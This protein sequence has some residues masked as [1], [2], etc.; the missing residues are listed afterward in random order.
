MIVLL[1]FAALAA[2]PTDWEKAETPYLKNIRQVTRDYVRAGEGYF[3]PDGKTI[4]FQAEEKDTGNPFYQIFLQ[5]LAT[6]QVRRGRAKTTDQDLARVR[7]QQPAART[8]SR[9]RAADREHPS[10]REN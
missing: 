3:S 9:N 6:G 2:D 1:A 5:D 4:L 7:D 8:G 10:Y